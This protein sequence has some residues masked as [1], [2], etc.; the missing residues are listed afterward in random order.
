[1]NNIEKIEFNGNYVWVDKEVNLK[2]GD[3]YFAESL[4]SIEQYTQDELLSPKDLKENGDLK[5]IATSP[6]LNFEGIPSW[7]E[8]KAMLK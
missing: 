3:W 6:E 4:N 5:I 2:R 7:A 1:M 8:Y